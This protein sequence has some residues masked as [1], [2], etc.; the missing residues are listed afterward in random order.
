MQHPDD[1]IEDLEQFGGYRGQHKRDDDR[2]EAEGGT[3]SACSSTTVWPS[4]GHRCTPCSAA[5]SMRPAAA[6]L[7]TGAAMS[8]V[9]DELL[10]P[11]F[12]F[13]APNLDYRW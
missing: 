9:A 10:T 3:G 8:V 2:R 12:G 4:S 1:G 13:S 6:G 5:T 7:A 11:A